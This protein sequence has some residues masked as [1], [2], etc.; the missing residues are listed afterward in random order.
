MESI[1]WT[2]KVSKVC[3]GTSKKPSGISGESGP[4]LL[5]LM[6]RAV[7][8]LHTGRWMYDAVA[9]CEQ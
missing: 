5:E 7:P 2:S 1:Q 6:L 8:L 3:M 4:C 9:A